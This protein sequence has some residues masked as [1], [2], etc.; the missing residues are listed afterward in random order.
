MPALGLEASAEW[1]GKANA[2]VAYTDLGISPGMEKGI[3]LADKFSIFVE[4]RKIWSTI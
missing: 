4:Y 1:Y 2:V 3:S